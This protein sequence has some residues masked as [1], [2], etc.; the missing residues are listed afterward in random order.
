MDLAKTRETVSHARAFVNHHSGLLQNPPVALSHAVIQ[1]AL[2][3][4]DEVFGGNDAQMPAADEDGHLATIEWV[5]KPQSSRPCLLTI[6]GGGAVRSVA[7]SKDGRKLARAEG[8]DVV[9]AA[10]RVG[11]SNAG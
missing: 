8:N 1:P 11:S 6:K 10:L 2:R 4:P 9:C 7:Y 3:E 5:N